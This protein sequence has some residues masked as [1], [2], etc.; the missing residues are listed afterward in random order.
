MKLKELSPLIKFC[1]FTVS[2]TDKNHTI[3][4][5]VNTRNS[6]LKL[7]ELIKKLGDSEVDTISGPDRGKICINLK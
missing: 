1:D 2:I 4:E 3:F 5:Y 7:D 6:F